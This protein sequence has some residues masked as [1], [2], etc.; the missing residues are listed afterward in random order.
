M[1]KQPA[2]VCLDVAYSDTAAAVAGALVE[3]WNADGACQLLVRRFEG[4]PA[5]YEPGAFYQRELPLLLP[6]ISEFAT[7][8]DAIVIDGYVW[9]EDKRPGLGGH[10]FASLGGRIPVIGVAKTRYR[11]DIWSIPVLRGTSTQPLFVTSAGIQATEAAHCVRRMHGD[12]RIPTILALVDG[13]ARDG[14]KKR[15]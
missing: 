2:I 9:L 5:S 10:L 11:N 12:H 8:I 1:C 7:S 3:G 13:A 15:E 14:L 4:P 6:V